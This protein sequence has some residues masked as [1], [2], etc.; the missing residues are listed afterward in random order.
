ME[1]VPPLA[2]GVRNAGPGTEEAFDDVGVSP[3][4]CCQ[5][6]GPAVTRG[7]RRVGSSDQEVRYHTYKK[8]AWVKR[9]HVKITAW[10]GY[11]SKRAHAKRKIQGGLFI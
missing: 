9:D 4:G 6:R 3:Q 2:G 5:E 11:G 8:G 10:R 1:G 7:G